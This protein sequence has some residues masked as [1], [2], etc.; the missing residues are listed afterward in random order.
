MFIDQNGKPCESLCL[1]ENEVEME[2]LCIGDYL[3]AVSLYEV[4]MSYRAK[5]IDANDR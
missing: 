3:G 5:D 2:Y 4:R 1:Q